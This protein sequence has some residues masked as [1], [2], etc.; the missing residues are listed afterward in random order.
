MKNLVIFWL[1][2]V[3]FLVVSGCSSIKTGDNSFKYG[4]FP[5]G[6]NASGIKIV[7]YNYTSGRVIVR[8]DNIVVSR[9][10]DKR[11]YKPVLPGEV[12]VFE[13]NIG[14]AG[15][16]I[17]LGV[18]IWDP[19]HSRVI[20]RANKI[21]SVNTR[22]GI[23]SISWTFQEKNEQITSDIDYGDYGGYGGF[24]MFGGY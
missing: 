12:F 3:S 22:R 14:Y 23:T 18:E 15:E 20:A 2:L 24:N 19:T 17:S 16:Q 4:F 13:Y 8:W 21:F 6:G 1:M 5:L 7:I 10:P 11:T 9:E